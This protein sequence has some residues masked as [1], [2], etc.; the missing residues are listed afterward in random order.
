MPP[1]H[2]AVDHRHAHATTRPGRQTFSGHHA[3]S[4]PLSLQQRRHAA[5]IRRG[6]HRRET[7][8]RRR[9]LFN[10]PPDVVPSR[11]ASGSTGSLVMRVRLRSKRHTTRR[12]SRKPEQNHAAAAREA[13][14][15][16]ARMARQGKPTTS[17]VMGTG[18]RRNCRGGLKARGPGPELRKR[19]D[20]RTLEPLRTRSLTEQV[21]FRGPSASGDR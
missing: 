2:T 4:M 21:K 5:E 1:V 18:D 15:R 9:G 10:H 20:R 11:A 19:A 6:Q 7:S 14:S 16:P 12:D 3:P 13:A 17:L 8:T